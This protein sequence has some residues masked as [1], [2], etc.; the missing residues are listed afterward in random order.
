MKCTHQS[1]AVSMLSVRAT[2]RSIEQHD[3][4]TSRKQGGTDDYYTTDKHA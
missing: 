3:S 2:T 4:R 1:K